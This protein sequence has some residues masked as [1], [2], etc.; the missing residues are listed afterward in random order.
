MLQMQITDPGGIDHLIKTEAPAPRAPGPGE[1]L[2]KVGA[3]SLNYHD[4]LVA[5]LPGRAAHG[6]VPL[7][8]C[9]GTVEAIGE[10]VQ[11]FKIGDAV[12]SCFFPDW[13]DGASM[14]SSF[15]RVPGDGIDGYARQYVVVPENWLTLAPKGWSHAQAA[16]I[17]TA[18]LTAWR[19]LV[20]DG[21]FKAGDTVL[22]MGTGG[23]SIYAL[24]LA[25]AMGARVI[26]TTSS[27]A[28]MERLKALGADEV[29]NYVR[30]PQWGDEVQRL[31]DG[32]G[33]RITLEVGGAGTL[34]QS[35]QATAVG[36]HIALIGILAGASSEVPISTLMVRQQTLRG[37][38]VGSRRHQQE[39]VTALNAMSWLPVLDHEFALADLAQAFRW[40][41]S[42]KHFGKIIV[43]I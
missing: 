27:E 31:T 10:Q 40:Q 11:G 15:D 6:R 14:P 26:A 41:A 43:Q 30:T 29:V 34:S 25:K 33:A 32:A 4:F 18:G 7:S 2:V 37:L 17:T 12:V 36:G 22:V 38:I 1:V 23:V 35:I 19:A 8:D 21:G 20:V 3:S 5:S 42:G 13:Q 39:F 28:K 16:T 24:Q 9:G